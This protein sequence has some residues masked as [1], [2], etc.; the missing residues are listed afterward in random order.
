MDGL[1]N[2][3]GIEGCAA[4]A[5]TYIGTGETVA[6]PSGLF[7]NK[8]IAGITIKA[9]DKVAGDTQETFLGL[10]DEVQN[11]AIK[12]FKLKVRGG[13]RELF[14]ECD[15]LD[16]EFFAANRSNLAMPL[17][18]FLGSELMSAWM[19]TDRINRYTTIN[20]DRAAEIKADCDAQF[21]DYLKT[22]LEDINAGADQEN[23]D[24]FSYVEGL[25]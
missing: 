6:T 17:L 16:D 15:A 12:K 19:Y 25:P 21:P 7:I 13:Y 22:A 24:V 18:Y 8:D 4:P 9:M 10:W 2:Y 11:R 3:I 20:A 14:N 5:Y 1:K 23:G